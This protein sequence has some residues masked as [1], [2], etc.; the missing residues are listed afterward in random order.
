[1]NRLPRDL[2]RIVLN[3]LLEGISQR[4]AARISGA[5]KGT[6]NKLFLDAAQIAQDYQDKHLRN[7][8]LERVQLDEMWGFIYAKNKNVEKAK[9]PPPFA[10]DVWTWIA[11]CPDTKLVPCWRVGD[12]TEATAIQF[13]KDLE[14]RLASRVQL[15]TDGYH[16]YLEAVEQGFG[17]E[18]D[19]A[20]LAKIY[21]KQEIDKRKQLVTGQP[22]PDHV[23][24]SM[25]ER[26]NLTVRMSLRRLTRKTNAHSKRLGYH[27]LAVA[28]HFMHYNFI[29]IHETL[30]MTPAMAADVTPHLYDLDWLLDMVDEKY[31]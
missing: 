16:P 20:M 5:A 24:T 6:V 7:L 14:S 4:A 27:D 12:R 19:Y 15:T 28:L 17:D 8:K 26:Q 21:T 9:N 18:V 25:V 10:G 1:M 22:D 23:S 2:Q 30:R 29:R 11:L 13:V 31:K 3:M